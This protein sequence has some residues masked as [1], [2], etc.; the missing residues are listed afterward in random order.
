MSEN[1]PITFKVAP[2]ALFLAMS[3]ENMRLRAR[4]AEL[5]E[6]L[7]GAT[8]GLVAA[9]SLLRR[10]GKAPSVK[11]LRIMLNDFERAAQ[12]AREKLLKAKP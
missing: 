7:V 11:M 1:I 6:V 2:D 4:V 8:A 10:G 9:T 5:E 12:A 3:E